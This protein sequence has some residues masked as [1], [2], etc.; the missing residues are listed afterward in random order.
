[1]L[2]I[3]LKKDN[4]KISETFIEI[5][6]LKQNE[7]NGLEYEMQP[8]GKIVLAS[9]YKPPRNKDL[10]RDLSEKVSKKLWACNPALIQIL[11]FLTYHENLYI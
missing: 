3:F 4:L 5:D 1:M 10:Q 2:Q 7:D 6:E 8:E 9:M 11:E